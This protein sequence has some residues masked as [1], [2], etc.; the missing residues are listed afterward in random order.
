MKTVMA[1]AA[2]GLVL[3]ACAGAD[4]PTAAV[5]PGNCE[6]LAGSPVRGGQITA[7]T[8][9]APAANAR[10]GASVPY[11]RVQMTLKPEPRSNILVELWL[12]EQG[13]W[14]GKFLGTG[15][16]G[17]AG[18]ISTAALV[19][20]VNRG[21]AVANTDMGSNDGKNASL[22]LNFGFGVGRPDLQKDFSYRSTDGMTLVGK[23]VT[24]AYYGRKPQY[25]YFQGCSTGGYQAWEQIHRLPEEYGGERPAEPAHDPHLERAGEPRLPGRHHPAREAGDGAA[26]RDRRL[27]PAGRGDRRHH[28][29]SPAVRLRPRGPP[30]QGRGPRRLPHAAAG[31]DHA[32]GL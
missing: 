8:R 21:Y 3:A 15:N 32:Q 28:Q 11:C 10:G 26:R 6:A 9:V 5:A 17:A 23:A 31:G 24:A 22:G 30:V 2:G 7:A 27:R 12:P 4:G 19:A 14:N 25:S 20:G 1:V 13:R 29:R 18:A 16:G